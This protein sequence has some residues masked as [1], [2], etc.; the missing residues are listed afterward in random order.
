MGPSEDSV[1]RIHEDNEVE[2]DT[3]ST[4]CSVNC[5]LTL[6]PKYSDIISDNFFESSSL[7]NAKEVSIIDTEL[8]E[9]PACFTVHLVNV[10]ALKLKRNKFK[11]FPQNLGKLVRV[12]NLDVS[13][14]C[15]EK[16]PH[17]L[18]VVPSL[19]CLNVASNSIKFIPS[20][21]CRLQY[22]QSL[23][24]SMNG[25]KSLPDNIGLLK[26]LIYLNVSGNCLE[27]LPESL[28]KLVKL[29]DLNVSRN[30]LKTIPD[31][32]SQ[33]MS[34]R[35]LN[36]SGNNITELPTC[37][38]TGLPQLSYLDVSHN[39]LIVLDRPPRCAHSLI[40]FNCSHNNLQE[41]PRWVFED[42]CRKLQSVDL[43]FNYEMRGMASQPVSALHGS[44]PIAC[45][46]LSNC[47]LKLNTVS[48]LFGLGSLDALHMGNQR[49]ASKRHVLYNMFLVLPINV[50][51][52][53]S[54]L[55]ELHLPDVGLTDLPNTI[56]QLATHLEVLDVSYNELHW[57]P[58]TFCQLKHL[59]RCRLSH[60][61]L[62]LLP[63][64]IGQLTQLIH[65]EI[66]S[67]MLESLPDSME[68]LASLMLLDLYDNQLECF[69][70]LLMKL[71]AL[72]ALDVD[73]N[74]FSAQSSFE[75]V[76]GEASA[77]YEQM[78]T[79]LRNKIHS[80]ERIDVCKPPP[81]LF[82]HCEY[83]SSCSELNTSIELDDDACE[84]TDRN[85]FSAKDTPTNG[86]SFPCADLNSDCLK[87]EEEEEWDSID[88]PDGYF[89]PH[90]ITP[91]VPP[92][93]QP[94]L[95]MKEVFSNQLDNFCPKDLHPPT[96]GKRRPLH[97]VTAETGQ[98]D[99]AD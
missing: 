53:C 79:R 85:S 27:T 14:N 74:C 35:S 19:K 25:L 63:S 98:F 37:I 81:D 96:I 22:L 75:K 70:N 52:T 99:D 59:T 84:S 24:I 30:R 93:P 55:R 41:T 72:E 86:P 69:P 43:S 73:N 62:A 28:C 23:N 3:L 64:E 80:V 94:V 17:D 77:K 32:L 20:S 54:S 61:R 95:H 87:Y 89:D 71:P 26:S 2:N 92:P 68:L 50:L 4:D 83:E 88:D 56:E 12:E 57:L 5:V 66:N 21:V 91:S 34:L 7:E 49:D 67:N 18:D 42:S 60:N 38:T 36:V 16:L 11:K 33:I 65:L 1:H 51:S 97:G 58:E 45:L 82:D 78:K 90:A 44:C 10:T 76:T 47:C 9:L 40:S 48:M 13:H 8:E 6:D 29:D 39:E 31:S 15:I 46:N